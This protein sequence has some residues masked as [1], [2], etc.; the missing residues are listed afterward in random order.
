MKIVYAPDFLK[1]FKKAD[2]R[3][4]NRVKE[5]ILLFSKDPSASQLNNHS[6]KKEFQ[7]YRSIDITNDWRT[8]YK[9]AEIAGEAVVYFIIF[10]THKE[11]YGKSS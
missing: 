9:E 8:I 11:L 10:G 1:K 6:L 3:I 7:G 2:V 4:R 5:Q